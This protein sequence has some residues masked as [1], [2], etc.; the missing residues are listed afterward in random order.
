MTGIAIA[1]LMLSCSALS[2][3]SLSFLGTKQS[4][5][6]KVSAAEPEERGDAL[7]PQA[8]RCLET[9]G[10]WDS[11]MWKTGILGRFSC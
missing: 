6:A 2:E 1:D 10:S 9:V 3:A 8:G 11:K 7:G 5:C 4:C